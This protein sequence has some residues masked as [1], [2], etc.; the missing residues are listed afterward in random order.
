MTSYS[1]SNLLIYSGIFF[2]CFLLVF[3]G[4]ILAKAE[5]NLSEDK[6]PISE[7]RIVIRNNTIEDSGFGIYLGSRE[8]EVKLKNNLIQG[9]GEGIRLLGTKNYSYLRGNR[10][11]DN[12]IG[13]KIQDTYSNNDKGLQDKPVNLEKIILKGN[14]IQGNEMQNILN[15]VKKKD[16]SQEVTK[17]KEVTTQT[18][19]KGETEKEQKKN[20]TEKTFSETDSDNKTQNLNNQE[21]NEETENSPEINQN[22]SQKK[23]VEESHSGSFG[24]GG[25]RILWIGGIAAGA[26]LLLLLS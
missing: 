22:T 16:E 18:T 15:E 26:V 7:G 3:G 10:I 6:K 12:V 24:L 5:E 17:E 21:E 2:A 13:L 19:E 8:D 14:K 20:S 4:S 1:E 25:N 23:A 9:N 11:T